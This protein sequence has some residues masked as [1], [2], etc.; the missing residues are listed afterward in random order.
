MVHY[1][2]PP[3]GGIIETREVIGEA[4]YK[5]LKRDGNVVE[6]SISKIDSAITK[7]FEAENK[8]Y[9]ELSHIEDFHEIGMD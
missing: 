9:T 7:A 5:V 3:G 6:F 4:M 8:Q 2:V 1:L